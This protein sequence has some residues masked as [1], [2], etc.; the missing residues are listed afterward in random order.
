M[1]KILTPKRRKFANKYAES[2][3]G[4]QAAYKAF[5]VTN[6]NSAAAAASR[7]LRDVKVQEAL[8]SM[9][10]N[11]ISAKS[12]VVEIMSNP[13]AD[14]NAR[15]KATDQVFKV[16]GSYAP[17]KSESRTLN[18]EVKLE[19]KDLVAVREKFEEELKAKLNAK[20]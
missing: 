13:N 6:D 17:E 14:S 16:E 7:A 3:N 19:N 20:S 5:E 10:F 8:D 15:L 9:G 12:V 18:V 11:E 1:G 2:G 4:T